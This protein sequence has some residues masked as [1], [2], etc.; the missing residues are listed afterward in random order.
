M[1]INFT[2]HN[3]EVSAAIKNYTKEKFDKLEHFDHLSTIHVVFSIENLDQIA[4]ATVSVPRKIDVHARAIA[5]NLYEAIDEMADK[6]NRQLL[7]HKEK[8]HSHRD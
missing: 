4:E 7:K 5:A 1:E 3:V 6:L 2:G 8:E